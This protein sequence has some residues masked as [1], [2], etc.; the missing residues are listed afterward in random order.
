MMDAKKA[1]IPSLENTATYPKLADRVCARLQHMKMNS[2]VLCMKLP[3]PDLPFK[4]KLCSLT[5]PSCGTNLYYTQYS[6]A[7]L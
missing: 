7:L 1:N 4:I 2:F 6:S 3:T 5:A